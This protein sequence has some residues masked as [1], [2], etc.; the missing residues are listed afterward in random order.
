M[1]INISEELKN[2]I[3]SN[4]A[5]YAQLTEF[6][7]EIKRS[8][9]ITELTFDL[10]DAFREKFE[11]IERKSYD[12][13]SSYITQLYYDKVIAKSEMPVIGEALNTCYYKN[14]DKFVPDSDEL[15]TLIEK[16]YRELCPL[17]KQEREKYF[18]GNQ[19]KYSN[20]IYKRVH[21]CLYPPIALL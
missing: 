12:D 15:R 14:R 9:N 10:T 3:D 13:L 5:A 1:E 8:H 21:S 16:A 19:D 18:T 7:T 11:E 4:L 20:Y 17:G 2:E 6:L